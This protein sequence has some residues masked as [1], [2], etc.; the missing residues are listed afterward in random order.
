[1]QCSRIIAVFQSALEEI[2]K[3][4]DLKDDDGALARLKS[5]IARTIAELEI[6]RDTRGGDS[7][8]ALL[9]FLRRPGT[10]KGG[11]FLLKRPQ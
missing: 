5:S 4:E 11:V 8:R 3:D 9:E 2:E 6:A 10:V 7:L 1:M